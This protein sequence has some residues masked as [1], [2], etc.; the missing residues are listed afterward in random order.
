MLIEKNVPIP[1][2]QGGRSKKYS[3][4]DLFEVGDSTLFADKEVGRNHYYSAVSW[5]RKQKPKRVF[6]QRVTIGG[7][8]IWR[9][10]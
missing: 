5:G 4:F 8:R 10:K 3:G 9:I 2:A 1:K 6:S 7:L